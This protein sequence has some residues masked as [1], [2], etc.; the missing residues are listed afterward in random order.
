M[1][2]LCSRWKLHPSKTPPPSRLNSIIS[3]AALIASSSASPLR[4]IRDYYYHPW[5][6]Q[7]FAIL[8]LE[9]KQSTAE[10]RAPGRRG[11]GRLCPQRF[12]L[13]GII[14]CKLSSWWN[15]SGREGRFSDAAATR[16]ARNSRCF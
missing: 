11:G 8:S 15:N 10:K 13:D 16:R 5:I 14:V 6:S 1:I 2:D 12:E 4:A 3:L 9:W 7:I